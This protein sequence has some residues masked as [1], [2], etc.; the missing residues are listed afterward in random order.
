MLGIITAND[1]KFTLPAERK[2]F[3]DAETARITSNSAKLEKRLSS[4]SRSSRTSAGNGGPW[5]SSKL[6]KRQTK[7]T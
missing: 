3:D 6:A 7:L 1:H 4:L 2:A 5:Y